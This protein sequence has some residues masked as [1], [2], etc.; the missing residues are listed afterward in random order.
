MPSFA[1]EGSPGSAESHADLSAAVSGLESL[2][3]TT[4]A[5]AATTAADVLV[6]WD[7]AFADA[8]YTAVA[9]VLETTAGTTLRVLKILAQSAASITVRVYND[10]AGSVTGTVHAIGIAD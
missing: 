5:V 2:R 9:S 10:S 3:V 7:T 4:G 6:T 1:V 8:N